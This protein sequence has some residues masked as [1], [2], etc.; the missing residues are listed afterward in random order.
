MSLYRFKI[1][2]Q[3]KDLKNKMLRSFFEKFW[4]LMVCILLIPSSAWAFDFSRWDGLLKR[5]VGPTT[6]AGVRLAG[7]DYPG[8]QKDPAYSKLIGDLKSF[9][10]ATLKTPKEKRAFWIN[11]YNIMAVKMVNG[12]DVATDL[13]NHPAHPQ[14]SLKDLADSIR[15]ESPDTLS[16]NSNFDIP[17]FLRKHAD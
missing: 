3:L 7:V 9:S 15:R 16:N 10:P 8:V 2:K 4:V 17:T 14:E 5:H 12:P 1:K 13:E 6:I 11:V